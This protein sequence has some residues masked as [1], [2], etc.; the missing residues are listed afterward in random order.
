VAGRMDIIATVILADQCQ[1]E[2]FV[3]K[4]DLHKAFQARMVP[5]SHAPSHSYKQNDV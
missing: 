4:L 5:L 1:S 3:R 2:M